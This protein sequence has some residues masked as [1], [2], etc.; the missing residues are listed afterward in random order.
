ML[1]TKTLI[2]LEEIETDGHSPMKFLCSDGEIYYCKYRVSPKL[3][4]LD[5]LVYEVICSNLANFFSIPT[6]EIAL[7]ELTTNC[8]TVKDIPRNKKY[9]KVGCFCF[10]SKDIR[11]AN[12]ITGLELVN[13]PSDLEKIYNPYDLVKIALFDLWIDNDDRGKRQNYNLLT[14]G[15]ENKLK[16]WAFDHAFAFG[17]HNNVR[18]FTPLKK[19]STFDKLPETDY[20]KEMVRL[21]DKEKCIEVIENMVEMMNDSVEHLKPVFNTIPKEWLG[22]DGFQTKIE[23]FLLDKERVLATKQL[24][25]NKILSL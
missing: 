25:I 23:S 10:G 20:F 21:L 8:F 1:I 3:E 11:N 17:G 15:F 7:V 18:I 4:E 13:S 6:P 16:I 19:P 22:F 2:F 5:C 9:A 24:L 12:L 14:S